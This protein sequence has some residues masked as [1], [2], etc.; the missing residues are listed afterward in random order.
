M[1]KKLV[2]QISVHQ[3]KQ[4]RKSL[5]VAGALAWVGSVLLLFSH[6][7]GQPIIFIVALAGAE[8]P[9][10][11]EFDMGTLL[12]VLGGMLGIGSLRTYEKQ[13]DN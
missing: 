7:V 12:T 4:G 10:L 6:F 13:K 5:K 2:A 9:P 11:P 1:H 8:I 3:W